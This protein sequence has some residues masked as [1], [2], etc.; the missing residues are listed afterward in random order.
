M[1]IKTCCEILVLKKKKLF[2][3]NTFC[4]VD[5][6]QTQIVLNTFLHCYHLVHKL[7]EIFLLVPLHLSKCIFL[8]LLS[9]E[10][11]LSW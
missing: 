10:Y 11:W 9:K 3:T 1:Y 8:S 6:H 4:Q 7:D 2:V 5:N